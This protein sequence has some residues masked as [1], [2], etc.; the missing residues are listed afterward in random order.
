MA[1]IS[2]ASPPS[3]PRFPP[4]LGSAMVADV[5]PAR[6]RYRRTSSQTHGPDQ[7]PCTSTT[8]GIA[9]SIG[10]PSLVVNLDGRTVL[11]GRGDSAAVCLLLWFIG[12]LHDLRER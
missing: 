6:S 3:L 11:A 4:T 5:M 9:G 1:A 12:H 2:S 7:A 10:C 8:V